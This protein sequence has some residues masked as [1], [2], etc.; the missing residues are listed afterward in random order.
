[1]YTDTKTRT[2]QIPDNSSPNKSK[3]NGPLKTVGVLALAAATSVGSYAFE[4]QHNKSTKVSVSMPKESV[5]SPIKGDQAISVEQVNDMLVYKIGGTEATVT[6]SYA[7]EQTTPEVAQAYQD[8]ASEIADGNV[9]YMPGV[10]VR[11][12]TESGSVS[13]VVVNPLVANVSAGTY[14]GDKA[15]KPVLFAASTNEKTGEVLLTKLATPEDTSW[16]IFSAGD[17]RITAA[18]INEFNAQI[19]S[20]DMFN[21]GGKTLPSEVPTSTSNTFAHINTADG[22]SVGV[23]TFEV[24]K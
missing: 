11:R 15:T 4:D 13:E 3:L 19:F 14:I 1:M 2:D 12:N 18:P 20:T 10:F 24:I 16:T 22:T 9:T 6:Y 21:A 5:A 23:T 7:K 17:A 8:V